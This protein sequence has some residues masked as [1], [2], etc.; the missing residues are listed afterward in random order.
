MCLKDDI[1]HG[2]RWPFLELGSDAVAIGPEE[3]SVRFSIKTE[4]DND[5]LSICHLFSCIRFNEQ[6][7]IFDVID[8]RLYEASDG[9]WLFRTEKIE[10]RCDHSP[11][12][13]FCLFQPRN[14]RP[15]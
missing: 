4:N 15:D 2:V 3:K 7:Q 13:L 12:L 1:R 11:H 10:S 5:F 6:T 8:Y 14:R 9:K